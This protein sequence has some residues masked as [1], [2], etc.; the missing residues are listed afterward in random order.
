MCI[1]LTDISLVGELQSFR[2]LSLRSSGIHEFPF[3][4]NMLRLLDLLN[5]IYL[6][7]V[8]GCLMAP[9]CLEEIYLLNSFSSWDFGFLSIIYHR[10]I[11]RLYIHIHN[12]EY[13]SQELPYSDFPPQCHPYSFTGTRLKEFRITVGSPTYFDKTYQTNMQITT[14]KPIST[15]V[16]ELMQRTENL[17]L[18][19]CDLDHSCNIRGIVGDSLLTCQNLR[20]L[21]IS[22]CHA[23]KDLFSMTLA[24]L[25]LQKL[26]ILEIVNCHGMKQIVAMAEGEE[27]VVDMKG[28]FPN[29]RSLSMENLPNLTSFCQDGVLLDWPSLQCI[30]IKLC[31][32]LKRLPLGI[33]SA[34][35]LEMIEGKNEW[36]QGLECKEERVMSRLQPLHNEYESTD[37]H[38][39]SEASTS[40]V[41]YL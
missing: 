38:N 3:S 26:E 33:H 25:G 41:S 6:K 18:F 34:A 31:P 4:L 32:R 1:H 5:T 19:S 9:A 20:K 14:S 2:V 39:P 13:L 36:F 16:K 17:S 27:Q 37:L 11:H 12:V 8:Q 10:S 24:A 21:R 7:K 23:F 40:L 29:L 30:T 28:L 22:I 35:K 15:W